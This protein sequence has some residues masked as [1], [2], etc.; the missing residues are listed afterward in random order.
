MLP[1]PK[2]KRAPAGQTMR[3]YLPGC[4]TVRRAKVLY[5]SEGFGP[6]WFL[7]ELARPR[8]ER[9]ARGPKGGSVAHFGLGEW[10]GQVIAGLNDP[11]PSATSPPAPVVAQP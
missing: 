2:K 8:R 9:R 6:E 3:V 10:V 5:R 1:A 7:I 11:V 4:K